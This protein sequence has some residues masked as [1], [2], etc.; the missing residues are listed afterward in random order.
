[1]AKPNPEA[2]LRG[3]V[4]V[5]TEER[6]AIWVASLMAKD[7]SVIRIIGQ[8]ESDAMVTEFLDERKRRGAGAGEE[9]RAV[10]SDDLIVAGLDDRVMDARHGFLTG[11]QAPQET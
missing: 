7:P 4:D 5:L 2:I 1:M 3:A 9:R 8:T 6:P 10:G 11:I